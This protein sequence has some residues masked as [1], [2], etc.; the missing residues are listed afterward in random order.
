M[1]KPR[2]SKRLSHARGSPFTS[3]LRPSLSPT[4]SRRPA[5]SG[6][7]PKRY[8]FS[9]P[10]DAD[11][12]DLRKRKRE[13]GS[14]AEDD[15]E[16][17]PKCA[18]TGEHYTPPP[19][20]STPLYIDFKSTPQTPAGALVASEDEYDVLRTHLSSDDGSATLLDSDDGSATLLNESDEDNDEPEEEEEREEV[21]NVRF[22]SKT[23]TRR[24]RATRA[25][26]HRSSTPPPLSAVNVKAE[27]ASELSWT[28]DSEDDFWPI[29]DCDI[30]ACPTA[31]SDESEQRC[32][33]Y[34]RSTRAWRRREASRDAEDIMKV[35]P[36]EA[37]QVKQEPEDPAYDERDAASTSAPEANERASAN[38]PAEPPALDLGDTATPLSIEAGPSES[39]PAPSASEGGDHAAPLSPG[40]RRWTREMAMGGQV[41]LDSEWET[42]VRLHRNDQRFFDP[43]RLPHRPRAIWALLYDLFSTIDYAQAARDVSGQSFG[44]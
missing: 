13:G 21:R 22:L 28:D 10:G 12:R 44:D 16:R 6:G 18:R 34:L 26:R 24:V 29:D 36:E 37:V 41:A 20:G 33:C 25:R 4:S 15:E 23:P 1:T 5:T 11:G 32:R 3:P 7:R 27:P 9:A 35:E 19:P 43:R 31:W 14:T 38:A 42:W 2:R 40:V 39:A 30:A 8:F 17:T